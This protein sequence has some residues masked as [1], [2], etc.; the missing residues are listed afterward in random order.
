[1]AFYKKPWF[2]YFKN[3][4]IGV[5]AA[6]VMLGALGKINSY[7]WGGIAITVGLVT[8]AI[9]FLFLGVLPPEKDYYWENLYPGLDNANSN[10]A[11]LTNGVAV[12]QPV[13]GK[14]LDSEFVESHL[15]GMLNELRNMSKS[16]QSLKALQEVDFSETGDQ[17][18]TMNNFYNKLNTAMGQLEGS[19]EDAKLYKENMAVLNQ[20]LGSLNTV[21]GN[22]LNAMNT[23]Q[24]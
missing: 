16:M 10:I 14:K 7:P 15:D 19:V 21:Y 22:M 13:N 3:F 23:K 8:E 6:L 9:I 12:E 11:P 1:M 2:K 20:K 5:G 4:I 24:Q 18:K 17:I